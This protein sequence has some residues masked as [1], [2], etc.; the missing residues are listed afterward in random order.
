MEQS[1]YNHV[2]SVYGHPNI[3]VH[4]T[5]VSKCTPVLK[6]KKICKYFQSWHANTYNISLYSVT[7]V[8][9][10]G[11]GCSNHPLPSEIPK[12]LNRIVPNSTR[13]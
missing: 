7:G 9:R 4:G 13:L 11:F 8:T 2:H 1:H 3:L 5:F 6:L 12:A 10:G